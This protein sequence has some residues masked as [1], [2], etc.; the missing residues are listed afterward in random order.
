[1]SCSYQAGVHSGRDAHINCI[2]TTPRS[3]CS[4]ITEQ[5]LSVNNTACTGPIQEVAEAVFVDGYVIAVAIF[6]GPLSAF[7]GCSGHR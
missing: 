3:A 6:Q 1:M 4:I 7:G 5:G 2:E